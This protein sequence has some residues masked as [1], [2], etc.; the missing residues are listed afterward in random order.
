MLAQILIELAQVD[1]WL[2]NSVSGKYKQ[3]PLA[4]DW[5]RISKVGEELGEAIDAFI[6]HTGQNP[7]KP[8]EDMMPQ[9]LAELA[10]VAITAILAIQ[11]FTKDE[12]ETGAI[13]VDK[14]QAI[15][16]R[17]VIAKRDAQM[18]ALRESGPSE[19]AQRAFM[20]G[21]GIDA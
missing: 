4:Q 14:V 2:D 19:D 5:A 11:H 13:L 10:D 6:I 1:H 8:A 17:M 3:Q 15:G 20:H 16:R 12:S 18:K 7:R 21:L 9:V